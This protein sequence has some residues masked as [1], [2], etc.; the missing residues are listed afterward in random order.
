MKNKEEIYVVKF[1]SEGKPKYGR[2][3]KMYHKFALIRNDGEKRSMERI[4]EDFRKKMEE[5]IQEKNQ[6]FDV[7]T[8]VSS[9]EKISVLCIFLSDYK[10]DQS[11]K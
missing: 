1:V 6:E 2:S 4:I 11:N 7:F 10:Q 3:S 5:E 9:A 8:K